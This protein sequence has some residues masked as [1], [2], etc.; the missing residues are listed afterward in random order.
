M[1]IPL[2]KIEHN[3][4]ALFRQRPNRFLGIVDIVD[5]KPEQNVNV[6]IHDPGRLNDILLPGARLLLRAAKNPARK[7]KW[8]LIAG[9]CNNHWVI[10]HSG[11]HRA[12]TEKILS[13]NL[14]TPFGQIKNISAEVTYGHSR[15]DFRL[16]QPDDKKIWIEVKGCTLAENGVA[17][18]PD[19]PTIRGRK[20]L[21]TLIELRAKGERAAV[22][23]LIFRQDADIFAPNAD[24]D[25]LFARSFQSAVKTGVEIYPLQLG[26]NKNIVRYLRNLPLEESLQ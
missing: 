3:A 9:F 6:H 26:F 22:I 16:T 11:Y 8:D 13:N 19:A 12:I 7:T 4:S 21:E 5:P 24:I 23:F 20:H 1:N 2:L 25:P 15:L 18:F 10:V 17:T 14:I